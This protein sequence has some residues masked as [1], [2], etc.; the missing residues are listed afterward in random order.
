MAPVFE[1]LSTSSST[2]TFFPLF[3]DFF[4]TLSSTPARAKLFD[5]SKKKGNSQGKEGSKKDRVKGS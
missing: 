4:L 3:C 2:S 5:E 1:W